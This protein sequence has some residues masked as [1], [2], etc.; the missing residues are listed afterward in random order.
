MLQ[1]TIEMDRD[2]TRWLALAGF[3]CILAFSLMDPYLAELT[4]LTGLTE[5]AEE[6]L[7]HCR[8]LSH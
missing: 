6:A 1:T 5:L 2:Q 3:H 4:E 7:S 8:R